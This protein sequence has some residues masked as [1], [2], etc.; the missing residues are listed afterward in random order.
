M[1]QVVTFV[2]RLHVT[3]LDDAQVVV[4]GSLAGGIKDVA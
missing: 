4:F 2:A 3:M 1:R